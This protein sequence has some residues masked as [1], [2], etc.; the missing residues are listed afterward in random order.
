MIGMKY[1]KELIRNQK[2]LSFTE[3][4]ETE[5]GRGTS[6]P[7]KLL[8]KLS[9]WLIGQL[10]GNNCSRTKLRKRFQI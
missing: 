6:L 2:S 10:R 8:S 7:D 5:T 1:R 9:L 3:V 4:N